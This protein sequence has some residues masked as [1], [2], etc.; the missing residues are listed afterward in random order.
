M[1]AAAVPAIEHRRVA[2]EGPLHRERDAG[3]PRP[4]EEMT[5]IGHQGPGENAQVVDPGGVS[6]PF[7]KIQA[8]GIVTEYI[9]SLDA[10]GGNVMQHARSVESR[11]SWHASSLRIAKAM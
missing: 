6:D 4:H 5:V 11:P 9:A 10:A 1:P 8:I 7:E 2:A 3:F